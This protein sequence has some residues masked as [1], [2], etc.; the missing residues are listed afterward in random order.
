M[1]M[2]VVLLLVLLLVLVS[3][4][5]RCG[6]LNGSSFVTLSRSSIILPKEIIF[7]SKYFILLDLVWIPNGQYIQQIPILHQE[8]Q[9]SSEI[10][11]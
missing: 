2:V 6:E 7:S 4:G 3:V 10:Y 1:V 9:T 5:G 11:R 8:R